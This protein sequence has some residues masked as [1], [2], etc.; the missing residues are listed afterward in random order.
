MRKKKEKAFERRDQF[1]IPALYEMLYSVAILELK[2]YNHL[3]K[4]TSDLYLFVFSIVA[5]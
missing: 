3:P 4:K 5:V 2:C 1:C